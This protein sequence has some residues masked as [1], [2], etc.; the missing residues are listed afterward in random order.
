MTSFGVIERYF[1]NGSFERIISWTVTE[2]ENQQSSSIHDLLAY[3]AEQMIILHQDKQ[4]LIA[5]FWTDLEGVTGDVTTFGKL[6]DKGKQEA[7]LAKEPAARPFVDPDSRSSRG[8]DDSLGWD[9]AAFKAFVR[10]LAGSV[11]HLSALSRVYND[12][13]PRYRDL[14]QRIER[15]DWLIDQIVYK[16]Y[17]LTDEEIA[18]VE[19]A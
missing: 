15:T 9:E 13:T 17:G 19:G 16:L 6:R 4:A 2:I 12:H 5:D 11:P 18:I 14:T 7:S 10:L 8:L 3:L 1:V